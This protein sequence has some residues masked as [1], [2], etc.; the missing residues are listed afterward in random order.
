[1]LIF[2]YFVSGY[3]H[4]LSV[5]FHPVLM[6]ENSSHAVS[7]TVESTTFVSSF[8][9]GNS[10]RHF[11]HVLCEAYETHREDPSDIPH[12]GLQIEMTYLGKKNKY[13]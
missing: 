3:D 12:Y 11:R 13:T 2:S 8:K 7:T 9:T 4:R 6:S 5:C 10:P 1:M